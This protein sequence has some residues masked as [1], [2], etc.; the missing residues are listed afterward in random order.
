MEY[1]YVNVGGH[2]K[3]DSTAG[4]VRA[5]LSVINFTLMVDGPKEG[6]RPTYVDCTSYDQHVVNDLLEGF[7][8][9]G[10]WLQCEGY[11]S[12]RTFTDSNGTKRSG[13]IVQ[14]TDIVD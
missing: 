5:G 6:D 9:A 7:V 11:L 2:V 1:N 4:R 12:F 8:N 13:L 3:S 10:E 14:V